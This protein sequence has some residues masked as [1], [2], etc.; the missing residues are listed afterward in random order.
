MPAYLNAFFEFAFFLMLSIF[1]KL[2]ING[3]VI[4]SATNKEEARTIISVFG[5]TLINCPVIPS[6]IS[7]GKNAASVVS[8]D[9]MIGNAISLTPRLVAV[10][11]EYPELYKRYTFST[12]T[13]ELST[14]IPNAKI[15]LYNTIELR[16]MSDWSRMIN[17]K[18]M[19]IGMAR[20]ENSALRN[21]R[22]KNSTKTT[23]NIP[24]MMLFSR[25]VISLRMYCEISSVTTMSRFCGRFPSVFSSTSIWLILSVASRILAPLFLVTDKVTTGWSFSREMV[26]FSL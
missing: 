15:R 2:A 21:P 23:K 16:V 1:I 10:S 5:K 22:N 20:P 24:R 19:E 4:T 14:S 11:N 17:D 8:V 6:H 3:G 12:T 26:D 18:N 9:E 13:I 25:L 7:R